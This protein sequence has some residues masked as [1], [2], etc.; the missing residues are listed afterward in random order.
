MTTRGLQLVPP[1]T[2]GS[3]T[4]HNITCSAEGASLVGSSVLT[5]QNGTWPSDLPTCSESSGLTDREKIIVGI[6]CAI[7][8]VVLLALLLVG[9]FF[10][11]IKLRNREK[12]E[13][14][15]AATL[16]RLSIRD[17]L[18]ELVR[19]ESGRSSAFGNPAY[20]PSSMEAGDPET[21]R[22]LRN[23]VE[24][25][26]QDSSKLF[27][28]WDYTRTRKQFVFAEDLEEL[29]QKGGEKLSLS[30]PIRV[31][32]EEDGTE[33][34]NDAVLRACAGMVFLLLE[35]NRVWS[36]PELVLSVH[37]YSNHLNHYRYDMDE[38]L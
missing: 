19:R 5:C 27:K 24:S 33:I 38:K 26:G 31:V 7:T 3:N 14:R 35:Q 34:D 36:K 13:E 16:E 10:C 9:V 1:L 12:R 6:S 30:G 17:P 15:L 23:S 25:A 29:V 22:D 11:R 2:S 37:E 8:G 21:K 20:T 32:L 4:T 18:D 28:V